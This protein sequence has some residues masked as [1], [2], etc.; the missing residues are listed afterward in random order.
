MT[1][2]DGDEFQAGKLQ[3]N[4]GPVATIAILA[5]GVA[6]DAGSDADAVFDDDGDPATPDVPIP[7]DARGLGFNRFI[8]QH[9]DVGA[10]ESQNVPPA[11]DLDGGGGGTGF[12]ATYLENAAP[13]Q[14]V[15]NAITI[16]DPND[17]NLAAATVVLAN[18]QA[19]D[20]MTVGDLTGLGITSSIDTSV[21]G[22]ITVT[23]TGPSLDTNFETALKRV[24]FSNASETPATTQRVLNIT[25]SD[26]TLT[27][28][29][30]TT[31]IDV[32]SQN[33]APVNTRAGNAERR[34]QSRPRHRR[35]VGHRRRCG[36]RVAHHHAL[37][38]ARHP[39]R[40]VGGRRC[41]RR[42]RHRYGDAHRHG[43]ADQHHA[44]GR[45]Q[46]ASIAGRTTS[47]AP[48]R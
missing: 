18:A 25:V 32:V 40:R 24:F 13:I 17:P 38:A 37:G 47:S 10:F 20:V 14:V 34:G 6:Y 46:R 19:G 28:P 22:Q 7:T 48:T 26:G 2:V 35:P 15:D 1:P 42:Q 44:R 30:A 39:R 31:T 41:G 8:G 12:A 11:I 27:S 43:R 5:G 16:D 3:N 33:D 21:A 45:E 29:N 23:L 4:G 9:V 36:R